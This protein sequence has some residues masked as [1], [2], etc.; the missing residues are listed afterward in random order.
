G[1]SSAQAAGLAPSVALPLLLLRQVLTGGDFTV[2]NVTSISMRQ[3]STP[4]HLR[5]RVGACAR[6]VMAGGRPVGA[7]LGGALGLW[8]GL[9]PALLVGAG[10]TLLALLP[11]VASPVPSLGRPAAPALRRPPDAGTR[12]RGDAETP[13]PI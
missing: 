1:P 2:L 9:G 6:V 5:G 3:T 7:L 4:D 10:L 11:L 13:T 8:A 12:G